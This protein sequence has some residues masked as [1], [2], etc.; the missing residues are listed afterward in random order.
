MPEQRRDMVDHHVAR[1]TEYW[2]DNPDF[3]PEVEGLITRI[4]RIMEGK[5][6]LD[7][8]AFADSDFTRE[9]YT[10]LHLLMVQPYPSEATPAQL[11]EAARVSRAAM[12]GRLD[13][14]ADAGM[15]TRETDPID[16]R[17]VIVRTTPR[18]RE[19]W[20]RYVHQGIAREQHLLRALSPD[21]LITLNTLLR[22][23]ILSLED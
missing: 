16:R 5:K 21:D 20:D 18:G 4:Q 12:T 13:R 6:R 23:V 14:L 8:A 11:A 17:R 10:T 7:A 22:R 2:K 3:D 9:D 19:T 1:W 15:V